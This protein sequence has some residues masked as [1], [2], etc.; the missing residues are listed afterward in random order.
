MRSRR[1][2]A[3][4]RPEAKR[5]RRKAYQAQVE[6]VYPRAKVATRTRARDGR[7][8]QRAPRGVT[9]LTWC[10]SQ[11]VRAARSEAARRQGK[12]QLFLLVHGG[13][14]DH[15]VQQETRLHRRVSDARMPVDTRVIQGERVS[16]RRHLL[17]QRWVHVCA[18][19]CGAGL[20]QCRVERPEI[21]DPGCS[22]GLV[23]KAAVKQN[24]FSERQEPHQARRLYNS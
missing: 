14:E 13:M 9:E 18:S 3:A 4:H 22:P 21:P 6:K 17:Y 24:D 16:Q 15:A 8:S 11:S 20:R 1:W 7:L 19:E 10:S 12:H 2:Y 5:R 23:E